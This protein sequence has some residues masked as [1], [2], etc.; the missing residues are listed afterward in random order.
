MEKKS[1]EQTGYGTAEEEGEDVG[2]RGEV[3][4]DVGDGDGVVMVHSGYT[5]RAGKLNC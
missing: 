5:L 1:T 4:Y 3:G 2:V